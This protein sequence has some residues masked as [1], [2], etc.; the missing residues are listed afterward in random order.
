M[1]TS[2]IGDDWDDLE[3]PP[4][5][6]KNAPPS[7]TRKAPPSPPK[8]ALPSS[9]SKKDQIQD[10]VMLQSPQKQISPVGD[11]TQADLKCDSKNE[12]VAN[13]TAKPGVI[14]PSLVGPGMQAH[15][16]TPEKEGDVTEQITIKG[17]D[18]DKDKQSV[19]ESKIPFQPKGLLNQ[20]DL[21]TTDKEEK[22]SE[23][24]LENKLPNQ[25]GSEMKQTP[26]EVVK[27]EPLITKST[28]DTIQVEHAPEADSSVSSEDL[29][30]RPAE[31]TCSKDIELDKKPEVTVL[32]SSGDEEVKEI[33]TKEKGSFV[34]IGSDRTTPT[35]DS[36]NKGTGGKIILNIRFL[37]LI[38]L[39]GVCGV[40]F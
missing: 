2:V 25:P 16:N 27:P 18:N 4:S 37:I 31:A 8:Q 24:K 39:K 11:K 12:K 20:P 30:P 34:M 26:Q 5:P 10:Q 29:T 7:P 22:T 32:E 35:S 21:D 38:P 9:G 14:E 3:A 40:Y 13:Q 33:K 36:T 28:F 6:T 23:N 17:A 19:T 1:V 15:T